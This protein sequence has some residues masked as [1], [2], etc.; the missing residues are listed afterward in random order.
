MRTPLRLAVLARSNGLL[1]RQRSTSTGLPNIG[2]IIR[3]N[4]SKRPLFLVWS[5]IW[6][7]SARKTIGE[8]AA[9]AEYSVWCLNA[10]F[11]APNPPI[12]VP[13]MVLQRPPGLAR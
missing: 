2:V 12:E 7:G 4:H 1:A 6:A 11:N 8:C 3:V 5:D 9:T 10:I 13:P